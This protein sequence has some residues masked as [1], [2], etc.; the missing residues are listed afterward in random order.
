MRIA[1]SIHIVTDTLFHG[2]R[3]TTLLLR[4]RKTKHTVLRA[5]PPSPTPSGTHVPHTKRMPE[6]S[7]FNLCKVPGKTLKT[8]EEQVLP[9][10][11]GRLW[12][13]VRL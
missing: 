12:Q 13:C 9:W 11:R 6:E 5:T 8:T 10:C 3:P 7:R 1:N 4:R 2:P